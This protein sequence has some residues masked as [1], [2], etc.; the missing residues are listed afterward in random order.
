MEVMPLPTAPADGPD[1]VRL[2]NPL[3][4]T[5]G[6]LRRRLLPGL[7]RLVQ[8]NWDNHVE[9][10]R[11]FEIGTVFTAAGAGERPREEY[12]VAAVLTG[13]R[14]PPHWTGTGESRIDLWDLRGQ[15]EVAAALAIPGGVVQV[16]GTGWIARDSQGR[17]VGQAG[18][19]EVDSPPWAAPLFGYELVLDPA[20]RQ[21]A[22][23]AALP[24]T[25]SSERVLALLLA[26]GTTV[27]Q[28]EELLRQSGGPLL[29]AVT[30]ESD[31]RGPELP[32]GAR[33][34]AFRLTFRAPDRTL[35]DSEIDA[36]ETRMLATLKAELR[37]QRRVAGPS[38]GGE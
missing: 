19:L 27:R 7:V 21:P 1:S 23:F 31:Y 10:V 8:R 33:S 17:T 5:E 29:E 11:L 25:P 35:R 34:V 16:E 38:G 36:I 20:L 2:L 28:V 30:I 26:E 12:H 14:E 13:R 3:S 6:Y 22:R 9:N 4:S 37:I 24:S 15:F 32:S 18:P